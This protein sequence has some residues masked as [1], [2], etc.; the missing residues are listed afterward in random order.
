MIMV[1]LVASAA[2]FAVLSRQFEAQYLAEYFIYYNVSAAGRGHI[3]FFA[4]LYIPAGFL[5]LMGIAASQRQRQVFFIAVFLF[6]LIL[7]ILSRSRGQLILLAF[8]A[9]IFWNYQ[10]HRLGVRRLVGVAM[11]MLMFIFFMAQF[12][13]AREYHLGKENVAR[14]F[15]GMFTEHQATAALLSVY[16]SETAPPHSYGKILIE[17]AIVA[18]LPRKLW[19]AKP[20]LYGSVL[21]TD[22]MVP[23]RQKGFYYTTG[24]FGAALVDFGYTGIVIAMLAIGFL[25][26]IVYEGFRRNA[27]HPGVILWYGLFCFYLWAFLRGG[28]GFLPVILEKTMLVLVLNLFVV[29]RLRMLSGGGDVSDRALVSIPTSL[30][31]GL[32][33]LFYGRKL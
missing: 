7:A 4:L 27:R 28:F 8:V 26:R 19:A 20:E 31:A 9:L 15:S 6:S 24:P 1:L 21:V 30:I 23:N 17:D 22:L 14:S 33:F 13:G 5:A 25:M 2:A 11:L 10:T 32:R 29:D 16:A 18:L 12:R 3:A